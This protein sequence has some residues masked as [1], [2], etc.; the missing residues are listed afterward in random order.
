MRNQVRLGL[1]LMASRK[2]SWCHWA[3][4]SAFLVLS[5]LSTAAAAFGE[6]SAARAADAR[7]GIVYSKETGDPP[8]ANPGEAAKIFRTY[9]AA[10]HTIGQGGTTGPDLK[11]VGTRR[12][13]D[14]LKRWISN[15]DLVLAEKDPATVALVHQY[16]MRMPNQ[17][18]TDTEVAALVTYLE[19]SPAA[20]GPAGA[21]PVALGDAAAGKALF[22]GAVRSKNGG[23]SCI[24]CH[25]VAGIGVLGGG[26]VGPDLT[27]A[28]T[29]LGAALIAW[30]TNMPVMR[31]IYVAAP[32][33][34]K[35]QADL[36]AFLKSEAAAQPTHPPATWLVGWV[37]GEA[38]LLLLGAH[39][40]WRRRLRDVRKALLR[41]R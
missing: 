17:H 18:L 2:R 12:S 3:S 34:D 11:G 25:G 20:P 24:A 40:T 35:E 36:L 32:L 5:V 9:C 37:G 41:R 10:C 4:F 6:P 14:W 39:L 22:T 8:Q 31:P 30:P 7:G 29:K 15:P 21:G 38:L 16:K 33:T 13:A 1:G 26:T 23:A 27:G 28:Y 19:S